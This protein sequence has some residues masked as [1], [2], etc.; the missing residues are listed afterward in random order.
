RGR[1]SHLGDH[2][3]LLEQAEQVR[4]GPVAVRPAV[5]DLAHIDPAARHALARRPDA[6][7]LAQVR[8]R[9]LDSPGGPVALDDRLDRAELHVRERCAERRDE[10][11]EPLDPRRGRE[12]PVFLVLGV[13]QLVKSTEVSRRDHAENRVDQLL[14][15][16][17]HP[18]LPSSTAGTDVTECRVLMNQNASGELPIF[19][20][21]S[22]MLSR[23][24]APGG[25]AA[26]RRGWPPPGWTR[27]LWS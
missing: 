19:L 17:R 21:R 10:L 6:V 25:R 3:E 24:T 5:P 2:A 1:R 11:S 26:W 23:A 18:L 20:P 27:P 4:A 12:R 22:L 16:L 15:V 14:P 8:A 9:P 13:H 7:E